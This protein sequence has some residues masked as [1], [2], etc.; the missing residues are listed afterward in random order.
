MK[1]TLPLIAAPDR[2]VASCINEHP[3]F[4]SRI[5]GTALYRSTKYAITKAIILHEQEIQENQY[6]S[7]VDYMWGLYKTEHY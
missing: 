6:I 3:R 5:V 4:R 1:K 2:S 7:E